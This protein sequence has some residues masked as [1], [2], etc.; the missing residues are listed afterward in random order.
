M[1]TSSNV[2]L[3]VAS[4]SRKPSASGRKL[5]LPYLQIL[6][7]LS[8]SS[9]HLPNLNGL[10]K[11][12][13]RTPNETREFNDDLLER[14]FDEEL[15]ERELEEELMEREIDGDELFGRDVDLELFEREPEPFLFLGRIKKWWKNRKGKKA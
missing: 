3:D 11:F 6:P 10:T 8:M 7:L 2:S 4:S 1:M 14:D 12:T 13:F 9:L 15:S 5:D